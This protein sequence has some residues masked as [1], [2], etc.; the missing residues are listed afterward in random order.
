MDPNYVQYIQEG[1]V[2]YLILCASIALHEFGHAKA[3]DK[4]GDFLPR[5]QG[6]V[7]LN[8]LVH[9]D[10]I[11]TGLIPLAT[12]FLRL[13]FAMIGWGRPVEIS[14]PNPATRRRDDILITLAGPAMNG[15]IALAA[16]FTHAAV[17]RFLNSA[18]AA[19]IIPLLDEVVVINCM[20]I[21]FNLI[22]I[23]PLDGSRIM[24]YAVGM[25]EE[26]FQKFSMMSWI[27]LIVL[28]N[29]RPFQVFLNWLILEVAAPFG[30][31]LAL[32]TR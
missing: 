26:V 24:R 15:L 11:G 8:P 12:I 13:P 4:L 27:L 2:A 22:P 25:S 32:L 31:L 1:L 7:T 28:I 3:A 20:L 29:L 19:S 6:R 30:M 16:T 18:T 23:P 21:A 17:W 10:P 14:L 9:L 5:S